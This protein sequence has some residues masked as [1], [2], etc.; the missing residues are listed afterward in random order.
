VTESNQD[1]AAF[2]RWLE[3]EVVDDAR[4]THISQLNIHP[5]GRFWL[6]TVASEE[7]Q[8]RTN[9]GER[10]ERLD[11]S[12]MG[13]R[14]QPTT[15]GTWDVGIEV[16]FKC[17]LGSQ[18][19]WTKSDEVVVSGVFEVDPDTESLT[20][21]ASDLHEE[22]ARI[23]EIDDYSP[24][25]VVEKV[26][27]ADRDAF[28]VL[29]VNRTPE[30]IE[31]ADST[32]YEAVLIVEPP[33]LDPFILESL[34]DSFRYDRRVRAYGVAC[35]V[36]E[37]ADG[38]L[39]SSDV[40]VA[41]QYK[42][43][44]WTANDKPP[45]LSFERMSTDP[46]DDLQSLVEAHRRW[47]KAEWSDD[48]LETRAREQRWSDDM[49]AAARGARGDFEAESTRLHNGLEA[50]KSSPELLRAFRLMNR[51][52]IHSSRGRY[53]GWRPF[54][55]GFILATLPAVADP[56]AHSPNADIVWFSTGGGKTETY[57]GLVVMACI[58]DRIRAKITGVTA[59]SR[60]PLRLLSLQQTQRFAD[61]ISGA[62]MV[63]VEEGLGGEPFSLGFLIGE[64][65]TPNRIDPDP[66]DDWKPD[67]EDEEMPDRFRVLL[68]CPFC[69][70]ADLRMSF[71]HRSWTLEHHCSNDRC[72]WGERALPFFVVDDEI[73]RFLPTVVV[74]TL[75]KIASL[76]IQASM[77][78]LFG[79]PRG[80][81]EGERHGHTYAQRSNR[82][83]GCLVPG[84][85]HKTLRL[86]M[87]KALYSPTFR[88]QDE[89]HLLRDALGAVDAHYEALIDDLQKAAAGTS[90]KILGSSATLSGY[91]HQA[92]VLYRRIGRVF[93][94]Q[95][96][97]AVESFWSAPSETLSR[98]HVAV[99]P[100]GATLE[101]A[102]DRI[103]TI[104]QQRVRQLRD[105]PDTL[106]TALG[107][108]SSS[109]PDLLSLYGT[110]VVYGNTI[111]DLEAASRSLETQI[112]VDG[113]LNTAQLTGQTPFE[114]V[115]STLDRLQHPEPDFNARVHVVT[116]SS[117]MSHGVD[118]DRLNA[119]IMLGLPLTTAEYIQTTARVGRAHPAVV[120]VLH[121]MARERDAS[122]YRSWRLFV[123]QGDRFV[124]PIPITRRSV[125]VLERTLPGLFMARLLHIHEPKM[126]IP[127]TTVRNLKRFDS[128]M[129]LDLD[130]EADALYRMLGVTSD[131]DASMREEIRTW[132]ERFLDSLEAPP[133]AARFP[134]ELCPDGRGPMLSL[135]D[136]EQTAPVQDGLLGSRR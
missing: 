29:L 125:R 128:I 107:I 53:S 49:W 127:L 94:A 96:P 101:F 110:C 23:T 134:S 8:L 135:R 117:M 40:I 72:P 100:R 47:G 36:E 85:E 20:L 78:G 132:L 32:L 113:P 39:R 119:M 33:D 56:T 52:L 28:E 1:A 13:F 25:V 83:R 91:E 90:P 45:D 62:E 42:P 74:G 54:Q 48:A 22:A 44:F 120:F 130:E 136:V 64:A 129:R 43:L 57:L 109:A 35:G 24:V 87:D 73:Y 75:D 124:D 15:D 67:P 27:G 10:G 133:D 123:S 41:D 4:G 11:P 34:P 86:P 7:K 103:V 68:E 82:P 66:D 76:S 21:L 70:S 55:M 84:C 88:L 63:R 121:K 115:R 37:T 71:D 95:G 105:D 69:F 3:D 9:L 99:A 111:R 131:L 6:G 31:G 18:E 26:H 97:T 46:M 50:L 116:A 98:R 38:R 93:P 5:S 102:N 108:D 114:D 106:C 2:A 58:Y 89:L 14:L 122:T 61:A 65:S 51:S 12:S 81:C 92:E 104:V 60:F 79:P 16:R 59:W 30:Q 118:V 80:L 17:W 112:P 126:D 77:A 19:D